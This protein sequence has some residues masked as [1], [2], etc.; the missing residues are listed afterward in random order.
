M[1]GPPSGKGC[2]FRRGSLRPTCA[3][4]HPPLER[5]SHNG[6]PDCS[7]NHQELHEIHFPTSR[8]KTSKDTK[9]QEENAHNKKQYAAALDETKLAFRLAHLFQTPRLGGG[10]QLLHLSFFHP[11]DPCAS[12]EHATTRHDGI[13][14][15]LLPEIRIGN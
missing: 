5:E 8:F 14:R 2:R 10:L 12:K 13:M 9:M 4:S 7:D 3:A 15:D 1:S 6:R 11:A